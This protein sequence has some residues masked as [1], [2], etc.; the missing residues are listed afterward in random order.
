MLP[1]LRPELER[2]RPWLGHWRGPGTMVGVTPSFI[3]ISFKPLFEGDV[4]EVI[5]SS[6]DAETGQC[7]S[8]GIG[9][10]SS[11]PDGK[12]AAAIFSPGLGSVMMLEVPDDPAA[13]A[14]EGMASGNLRFTVAL[15]AEGET[16]TLTAR[17]TEG[18]AGSTENLTYGVMRR[19]VAPGSRPA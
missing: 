3:E 11:G 18:Y 6:W 5:S 12:I 13:V 16:L 15:L 2:F 14:I 17:K 19:I 10:W 8:T 4:L 1:R 9:Y 7:L